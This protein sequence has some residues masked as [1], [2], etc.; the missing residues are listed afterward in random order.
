M[1]SVRIV[2]FDTV[3]IISS[4]AMGIVFYL[5]NCKIK[6]FFHF[7]AILRTI[8]LCNTVVIIFFSYVLIGKII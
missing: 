4:T 3:N 8:F 5:Y 2:M 1:Y 6:K 7:S